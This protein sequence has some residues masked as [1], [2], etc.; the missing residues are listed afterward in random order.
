[1][2]DV[3][4]LS[5]SRAKLLLENPAKLRWELDHPPPPRKP[6]FDFGRAAHALV[7]GSGEPVHV[8]DVD[9]WRTKAAREE[10]EA[11]EAE[12]FIVVKRSEWEV[13]EAMAE[14][15]RQHPVARALF[16]P[17][18]GGEAERTLE[19]VDEETGCPCKVRLDWLPPVRH[20]RLIVPDYKTAANA[21]PRTFARS[22][23]NFDYHLQ[24]A[25][26]LAGVRAVLGV[27]AA[28]VLVVQE[29]EAPYL[30]AT[31]ELDKDV[32]DV[33][34]DRMRRAMRLWLRCHETG[35]WPGYP[36]EVQSVELPRWAEIQH[37]ADLEAWAD[38]PF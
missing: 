12:G 31:Y 21:A 15:I 32:L 17:S 18:V 27:P 25:F 11:K 4:A 10:R 37:E 34:R 29:R 24:A 1:M 9:D 20:G 28:F 38:E 26:T 13:V 3:P 6:E 8:V 7:L 23:L 36:L 5:Y 19:W 2:S 30:I 33:G 35:E 22:A 16:N 14:A